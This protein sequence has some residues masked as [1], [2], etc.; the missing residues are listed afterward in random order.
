[1]PAIGFKK[2]FAGMVRIGMK[3]TTIRKPRKNPI[4]AGDILRLYTGLRTRE[5]VFLKQSECLFT[6]SIEV[7]EENI[8]LD[9]KIVQNGAL[10][11]VAGLEGF[12]SYARMREFFRNQYGLPFKGRIIVW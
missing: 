4:K 5:C 11:F 9:G 8:K 1:M 12:P 6:K 2:E 3:R 7:R 10:E